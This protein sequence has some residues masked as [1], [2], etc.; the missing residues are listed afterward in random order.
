MSF[1]H[2]S[3]EYST[4]DHEAAIDL[5]ELG[6]QERQLVTQQLA[7]FM[8]SGFNDSQLIVAASSVEFLYARASTVNSPYT[9]FEAD[10]FARAA[11]LA[12]NERDLPEKPILTNRIKK[13]R[14]VSQGRPGCT[15]VPELKLIDTAS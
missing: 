10:V 9:Y 3:L 8:I 13:S 2:N 15:D 11:L 1:N 14:N 5:R 12:I 6:F 7:D 4:P